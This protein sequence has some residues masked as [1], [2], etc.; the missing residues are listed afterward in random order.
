MNAIIISAP[1]ASDATT[2]RLPQATEFPR[3][4]RFSLLIETRRELMPVL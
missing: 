2:S 4:S 1:Q 3:T